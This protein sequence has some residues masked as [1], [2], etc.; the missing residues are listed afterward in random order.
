MAHLQVV[1]RGEGLQ[2]WRVAVNIQLKKGG[3]P[4]WGIGKSLTTAT[5]KIMHVIKC[6]TGP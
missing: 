6:Y 4:A 1:D 2:T 5:S 3:P